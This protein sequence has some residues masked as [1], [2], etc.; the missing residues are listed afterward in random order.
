MWECLHGI[1]DVL[2]PDHEHSLHGWQPVHWVREK[3]MGIGVHVRALYIYYK[4]AWLL[5]SHLHFSLPFSYYLLHCQTRS[6][7]FIDKWKDRVLQGVGDEDGKKKLVW[8]LTLCGCRI[9]GVSMLLTWYVCTRITGDM[10]VTPL[11]AYQQLDC[12]E[13]SSLAWVSIYW[14][15][16]QL[17]LRYGWKWDWQILSLIIMEE[18]HDHFSLSVLTSIHLW[19]YDSKQGVQEC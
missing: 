10:Y 17:F 8:E 18:I 5:L 6:W 9:G 11:S 7:E 15:K 1:C 13:T 16:K 14:P 4:A 2:W 3:E 12:I 19:G